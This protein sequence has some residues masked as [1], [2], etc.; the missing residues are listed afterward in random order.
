M[1]AEQ[2]LLALEAGR[3]SVRRAE[4]AG[5]QLF[6]GGEMGIGNT[7]AA[8]AMAC[9]LLDAPASALVG[10]GTGLDASGVAHKTAVIERALALHG[11]HRADPSK[12]SAVSVGWR[13]PRWPAPTWPARR[14]AW[15]PWSTATSAASRRSARCA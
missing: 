10:P 4:Q 9:A 3:E 6:I 11:A 15:S 7:T 5:S 1:G 8:A 13:S 2:C 12:P 14:K